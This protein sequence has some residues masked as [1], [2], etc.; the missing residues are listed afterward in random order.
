MSSPSQVVSFDDELLI[1][2]NEANEVLDY[3][4]KADCHAD[5]GILH[6]AFSVFIF[7]GVGRLLLQQR[8]ATKDLWP[9]YWSNSCC[10]HPRKGEVEMDAAGRRL[11]EELDI[12]AKLQSL[13]TFQYHARFQDRGSERE[14]CEVFLG[15]SSDPVHGNENEIAAWKWMD[16]A[17]FEKDL[18]RNPGHYTPWL[19]LEWQKM[20]ENHWITVES[21]LCWPSAISDMDDLLKT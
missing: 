21:Y 13:F 4:S 10:S 7:D 12:A 20:R 6:R 5:E 16:V 9:L 19:K 3:R 17:E 2:V 14:V 15:H 11:R 8:S 18:I 1:V